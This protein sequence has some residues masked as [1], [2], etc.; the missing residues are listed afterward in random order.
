MK[1]NKLQNYKKVKWEC[2]GQNLFL[3]GQPNKSACFLSSDTRNPPSNQVSQHWYC[4]KLENADDIYMFINL[5]D[6]SG[7]VFLNGQ[8]ANGLT[9]LDYDAGASGQRWKVIKTDQTIEDPNKPGE[10][11]SLY[12]LYCLGN[13]SGANYLDGHWGTNDKHFDWVTLSNTTS[14]ATNSGTYWVLH[15]KDE[16]E[17]NLPPPQAQPYTLVQPQD[18]NFTGTKNSP[19]SDPVLVGVVTVPFPFIKDSNY[20]TRSQQAQ[21]CPLYYV[22][23][24]ECFYQVQSKYF[25]E[26]VSYDLSY[27]AGTTEAYDRNLS[28]SLG[29]SVTGSATSNWG[30]SP[31]NNGSESISATLTAN[32]AVTLDH[33]T[34]TF[35]NINTEKSY[36]V[37]AGKLAVFW[38][39]YDFLELFRYHQWDQITAQPVAD[40]NPS[41][42]VAFESTGII[43]KADRSY[44]VEY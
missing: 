8:T 40:W 31:E 21:F 4:Y 18:P 38:V 36:T 16:D 7:S 39:Y 25:A 17:I 22:S 29:F 24:K 19:Y 43:N 13:V 10:F 42:S 30:I 3:A 26:Q 34:T 35:V 33:S 6:E 2:Y 41:Q 11:L 23:H 32:L 5:A 15:A 9:N 27:A 20:P 14:L 1:A 12:N 28:V 37:S 44:M